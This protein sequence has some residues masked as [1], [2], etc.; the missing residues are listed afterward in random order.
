MFFVMDLE[1]NLSLKSIMLKTCLVPLYKSLNMHYQNY[2]KLKIL[3]IDQH[4][5]YNFIY[6]NYNIFDN[7]YI[8]IGW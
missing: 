3:I 4:L 5:Q 1:I 6:S 7:I 8:Y 2:D